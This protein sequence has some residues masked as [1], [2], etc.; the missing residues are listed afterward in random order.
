MY[1][2]QLPEFYFWNQLESSGCDY[3][4]ACHLLII[5]LNLSTNYAKITP[6]LIYIS[7][8]ADFIRY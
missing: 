8:E 3:P 5:V 4:I 7:L 2:N 6:L 1:Y